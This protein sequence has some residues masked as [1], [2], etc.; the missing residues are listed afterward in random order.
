V[1]G[2]GRD[3]WSWLSTGDA[4]EHNRTW[5]IHTIAPDLD[6]HGNPQGAILNGTMK[7]VTGSFMWLGGP[8]AWYHTPGLN[9]SGPGAPEFTVQCGAGGN[10]PPAV[11]TCDPSKAPCLFDVFSDPC[12]H[13]DIAGEHPDVVQ[14]LREQL[15]ELAVTRK[16]D[17]ARL[18]DIPAS[19]APGNTGGIWHVCTGTPP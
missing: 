1:R 17:L 2:D 4:R 5:I 11:D 18:P 16:P 9:F 10:D 14:A 3:Q 6:P 15:N 8:K 7:L 12:E 13:H 19:C